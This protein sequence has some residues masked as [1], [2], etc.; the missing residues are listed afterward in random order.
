MSH[1]Y[2]VYIL[3]N[4]YNKVLY[5]GVTNNLLRRMSEHK[6]KL[7]PS[8]TKKYNC[9]KLVYQEHFFRI[10]DAIMREKQI[11]GWKR[12]RKIEL[13]EALNPTWLDLYES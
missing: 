9:D 7:N 2:Y 6:N 1:N 11:K 10:E 5:T 13:I 12:I 3:T 4:E 8:F